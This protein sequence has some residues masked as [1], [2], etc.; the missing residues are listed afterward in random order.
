VYFWINYFRSHLLFISIGMLATQTAVSAVTTDE[1]QAVHIR[2]STT[3]QPIIQNFAEKYMNEHPASS[4]V[5]SGGRTARGYKAV[6]EGTADIGM[7]SGDASD[8]INSEL[9]RHNQKFLRVIVGYDALVTVVHPTNK[10]N[11]L[12]IDQ[13]KNIFTGRIKNWKALGGVDGKIEVLVGPPTGGITES[14]KKTILGDNDTY[15]PDGQVFDSST[16][17]KKIRNR[18]LAITFLTFDAA[19]QSHDIKI[20]DVDGVKVNAGTV[21]N[22]EYPLRVPLA[23]ITSEKPSQASKNFIQYVSTTKK[24]LTFEADYPTAKKTEIQIP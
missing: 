13:L 21:L 20:L 10:I 12:R 1:S 14:W 4:I 19:K 6:L 18:P 2:G 23:L 8:E 11:N 16:R 24:T 15:T 7:V 22:G 9:A 5:V 17:L 3:L